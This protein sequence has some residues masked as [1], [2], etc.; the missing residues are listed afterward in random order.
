MKQYTV[1]AVY[2]DNYQRYAENVEAENPVHA[3]V[4]VRQE[5]APLE[6]AVAGVIEGNHEC[7]DAPYVVTNEGDA[8][9]PPEGVPEGWTP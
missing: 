8:L 2:T 6:L 4:L 1:L 7:A 5:V 9:Y 3:E